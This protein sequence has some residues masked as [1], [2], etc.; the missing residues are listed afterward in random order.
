MTLPISVVVLGNLFFSLLIC[1]YYYQEIKQQFS[2]QILK[3]CLPISLVN[4]IGIVSPYYSNSILSPI[5]LGI[6]SR[7]YLVFTIILSVHLLHEKFTKKQLILISFS[8]IGCICFVLRGNVE[9]Y[10]I[11]NVFIRL[12]S[13]F[14]FA[15]SYT[16]TKV[17][18]VTLDPKIMF[19]YNNLIGI[20]PVYGYFILTDSTFI[21]PTLLEYIFLICA[22]GCFFISMM[23]FFKNLKFLSFGEANALRSLSPVMLFI[24]S[25]PFF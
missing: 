5:T 9:Q 7:F 2:L 8:I 15:I 10:S 13:S 11:F 24:I 17:K 23:L 14:C 1:L 25:F 19:F 21:W 4:L 18:S 3:L 6:L 20:L 16:L 22:A 12:L